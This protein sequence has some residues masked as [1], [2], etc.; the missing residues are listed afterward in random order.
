[1]KYLYLSEM[2]P[3]LVVWFILAMA[4]LL[5]CAFMTSCETLRQFDLQGEVAYIFDDGSKARAVYRDDQSGEIYYWRK[6]GD[7]WI[8]VGSEI[9][10]AEVK[11]EK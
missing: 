8:R 10:P 2:L 5:F 4:A 9:K 3:K 1:M 6:V 7:S 11:P